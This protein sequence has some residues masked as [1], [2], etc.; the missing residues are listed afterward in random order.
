MSRTVYVAL[1][2]GAGAVAALVF[3]HQPKAPP[4]S[5]A[6]PESMHDLYLARAIDAA[7]LSARACRGAATDVARLQTLQEE[8]TRKQ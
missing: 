8:Q 5:A 6:V 3:L 4:G 2:L 7:E 1:A